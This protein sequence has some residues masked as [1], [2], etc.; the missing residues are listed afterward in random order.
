VCS[1]NLCSRSAFIY[2][3]GSCVHKTLVFCSRFVLVNETNVQ[4]VPPT[5]ARKIVFMR[6]FVCTCE[7][8]VH[9][10]I[11]RSWLHRCARDFHD[12]D[13]LPHSQLR[14][15]KP[16]NRRND[17]LWIWVIIAAFYEDV[18]AVGSAQRFVSSGS[19]SEPLDP[20]DH[21]PLIIATLRI[22]RAPIPAVDFIRR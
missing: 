11:L 17:G 5:P 1:L 18:C 10:D 14:R 4:K 19:K 6:T 3:R 9:E 20:F 22:E 16:T 7:I 8:G 12:Q 2:A 15:A 21:S 13:A